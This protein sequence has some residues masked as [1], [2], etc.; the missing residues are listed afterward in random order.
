MTTVILQNAIDRIED[1]VKYGLDTDEARELL[2][3]L[4]E[5]LNDA[6][7]KRGY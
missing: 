5:A 4:T 6:K 3:E 2:T 7:R 1:W